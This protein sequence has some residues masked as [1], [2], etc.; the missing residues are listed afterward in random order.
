MPVSIVMPAKNAAR[1]IGEA[2]DSVLAQGSCVSELIVVDDGSTDNTTSLVQGYSDPRI[3][4]LANEGAG[5]SAARNF[6]ARSAAGS[7][8]MFLDADDRL[9]TNAVATLLEAASKAAQA[10]LIYGDY[11]RIDEA[12]RRIGRRSLLKYRN[13]PSGQV[14]ERIVAGSFIVNGGVAIVRA[15]AFAAAGGFDES[16]RYCEDWHCWC[17]L[18]ATGEFEFVPALLLDYRTHAA[19]TMNAG[20]RTP[21]DF[22]PAVERVFSDSAILGKLPVASTPAL[23]TAAEIHLITYAAAQAVRIGS[24]RKALS[25]VGMI[26]QRSPFAAPR[27]IAN[28]SLALLGI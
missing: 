7:W 21:Q 1:Y 23:R 8:L 9:R 28:L 20:T 24:Y 14:L 17:R 26:G 10:I 4:L 25:Y 12:G 11:D 15:D 18:A 19:N 22:F 2:I 27:A 5:V 3:R 13:K 6:G 16:L